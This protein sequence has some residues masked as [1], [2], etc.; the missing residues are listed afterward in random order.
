MFLSK[1]ESAEVL[2][3]A[4]IEGNPEELVSD[5][6]RAIFTGK[7]EPVAFS[8]TEAAGAEWIT[9]EIWYR[10][11]VE[12][13]AE[14]AKA[15]LAQ[16]KNDGSYEDPIPEDA[17]KAIDEANALVEMAETAW[18]NSIRGPQVEAILRLARDDFQPNGDGPQAETSEDDSAKEAPAEV[19]SEAE[20]KDPGNAAE[21]EGG[22]PA[23]SEEDLAQVEPWEGYSTDTAQDIIEGI[24]IYVE[25]D[26]DDLPEL[27]SHI[28]AYE[29]A[30]KNRTG[31]KKH[32]EGVAGKVLDDAQ[33]QSEGTPK[34]P[35]P[36]SAPVTEPEPQKPDEVPSDPVQA[37][38]PP[39]EETPPPVETEQPP[40]EPKAEE[41]ADSSAESDAPGERP[42]DDYP[43][44]IQLVEDELR[45]E[46]LHIPEP[47][48]DELPEVPWDWTKLTDKEL[49]RLHSAYSVAAYY[50]NYVLQ[51][52]ERLARHHKDA[53]D[54]LARDLLVAAA[55]YDEKG[56]EVKVTFIEAEIEADENV[57]IHRKR[58]RRHEIYA[59]AARQ[60]RDSY[61]KLVESL[62]RLETMRQN[63]HDRS[64]AGKR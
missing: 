61:N 20:A 38:E 33:A 45:R 46:R 42:E 15:I 40:E 9:P 58:Q 13:D 53:A 62:S 39:K 22:D 47:P 4:G 5:A 55:K 36:D 7:A 48:Q 18:S 51:R 12:M 10:K 56:K 54:E 37:P 28:W 41:P 60:E 64:A 8:V 19:T 32:L 50:K 24:N 14:R 31:V 49:H 23:P 35:A 16:A 59:V 26:A 63:E 44:L 29:E 2:R 34:L 25:E 17:S 21:S 30:H 3:V 57:K 11:E 1:H 43:D 6:F 27:L 52:E